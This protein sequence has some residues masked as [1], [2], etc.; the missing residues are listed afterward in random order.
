MENF[1]YSPTYYYVCIERFHIVCNT[2]K[3]NK[4]RRRRF[5]DIIDVYNEDT[6]VAPEIDFYIPPTLPHVVCVVPPIFF[7]KCLLN[8]D[9]RKFACPYNYLQIVLKHVARSLAGRL[10]YFL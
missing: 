1:I 4:V 8:F 9:A 5:V 7:R 2:Y 3:D 10:C 6:V